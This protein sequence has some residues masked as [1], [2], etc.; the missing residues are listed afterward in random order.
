MDK[1]ALNYDNNN[2]KDVI[3][4]PFVDGIC[5]FAYARS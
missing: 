3:I 4:N 5:R 1:F 2:N